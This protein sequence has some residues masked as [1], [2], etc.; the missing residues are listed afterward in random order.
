MSIVGGDLRL[1][2]HVTGRLTT[3][4][5]AALGAGGGAWWG[6]FV[7]LLLGVFATS[8]LAPMLAGLVLGAVF[9]AGTVLPGRRRR[10]PQR[11][12]PSR[13]VDGRVV[14]PPLRP[15][16]QLGDPT[17]VR[18]RRWLRRRRRPLGARRPGAGGRR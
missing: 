10:H 3:A 14:G 17:R 15:G 12:N 16:E 18:V 9:G 1:V 11:Q 8:F 2:E 4:R 7:G 6:P 13:A 5:A